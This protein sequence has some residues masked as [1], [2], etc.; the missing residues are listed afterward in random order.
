MSQIFP[1]I[2]N[3]YSLFINFKKQQFVKFHASLPYFKREKKNRK[4]PIN[5]RTKKVKSPLK[6][7]TILSRINISINKKHGNPSFAH[8]R[9]K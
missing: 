9:Q 7:K 3:N 5:K 8:T 4:Q 2:I 6:F 1:N